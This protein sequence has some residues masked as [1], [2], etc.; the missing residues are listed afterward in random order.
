M[1]NKYEKYINVKGTSYRM[2]T[3]V[4]QR[5]R[6]LLGHGDSF[7]AIREIAANTSPTCSI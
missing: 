5:T 6:C 1:S 4:M 2:P 7:E 3:H